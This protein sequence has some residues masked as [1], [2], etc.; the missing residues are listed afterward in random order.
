METPVIRAE[1]GMHQLILS[2][3]TVGGY[4]PNINDL[5]QC[6]GYKRR[7]TLERLLICLEKEGGLGVAKCV[8]TERLIDGIS[9]YIDCY[10]LGKNFY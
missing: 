7:S 3:E 4:P 1:K 10:C 8:I 6:S 5:F 9:L 2:L